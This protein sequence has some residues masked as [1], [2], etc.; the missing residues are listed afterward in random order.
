[1]EKKG[2]TL[3][4][5]GNIPAVP[6]IIF[7]VLAL[8]LAFVY[9]DN[10]IS[11]GATGYFSF[12]FGKKPV[13]L[14]SPDLIVSQID[15]DPIA[16]Y[17]T[18]S[19]KNIG[20]AAS[21]ASKLSVGWNIPS[22]QTCPTQGGGSVITAQ[23]IAN[24]IDEKVVILTKPCSL[25]FDVPALAI[26]QEIPITYVGGYNFYGKTVTATADYLGSTSESN[27][28][29]NNMVKTLLSDLIVSD[30]YLN[31][32]DKNT[33]VYIDNIGEISS[34]A[35]KLSFSWDISNI[36]L[37]PAQGGSTGGSFTA[38]AVGDPV[39]GKCTWT[40]DVSTLGI[41]NDGSRKTSI[42][43]GT[44][45]EGKMVTASVDYTNNISESNESNNNMTRLLTVGGCTD[46]DN[47]SRYLNGNNPFVKGTCTDGIG[48]HTDGCSKT[49]PSTKYMNTEWYCSDNKCVSSKEECP[50]GVLGGEPG[51]C[52]SDGA[53]GKS[54]KE[55]E[56][57]CYDNYG[58]HPS[59][60]ASLTNVASWT[61][62]PIGQPVDN[63]CHGAFQQAPCAAGQVCN[64]GSCVKGCAGWA[65]CPVNEKCE[66]SACIPVG[67]IGEGS[68]TPGV[69]FPSQKL[70]H[71]DHECCAGLTEMGWHNEASGCESG[72]LLGSG[73]ICTGKCGN[74][75][76]DEGEEKCTCPAD[77]GGQGYYMIYPSVQLI[78]PGAASFTQ[79]SFITFIWKP[80]N[81]ST[82]L[83]S[84]NLTIIHKSGMLTP[85]IY[86]KLCMGSDEDCS[87]IPSILLDAESFPTGDYD[88]NVVCGSGVTSE[89]RTFSV[90][91]PLENC[92][93]STD[94]KTCTN[95]TGTYGPKCASATTSKSYSCNGNICEESMIDWICPGTNP[96]CENG[97][98]ITGVPDIKLIVSGYNNV[99]QGSTR[100]FIWRPLY[101]SATP[102]CQLRIYKPGSSEPV[103]YP[104]SLGYTCVNNVDCNSGAISITAADFPIG[105]YNWSVRCDSK[106]LTEKN[107]IS[108]IG[109]FN[110]VPKTAKC[111]K[112]GGVDLTVKGTCTDEEGFQEN[113]TCITE[114]GNYIME[115]S[116][117]DD[118]CASSYEGI[119]CGE[120]KKCYKG[121]CVGIDI[122]SPSNNSEMNSPFT[123][124][125]IASGFA[126]NPTC[127]L[128]LDGIGSMQPCTNG[129]E[130]SKTTTSEE[131]EDDTDHE[132]KVT[133]N[134]GSTS[135]TSSALR[136][137]QPGE[138][139]DDD[140][141]HH[142]GGTTHC[143][144]N[145]SCS[146]WS[147]CA[148]GLQTRT[149][150]DLKKCG[151]TSNRPVLVQ[152]CTADCSPSWGCGDWNECAAGEK[153]SQYCEDANRC[154][155]NYS[156]MNSRDCCVEDWQFS[157][158]SE[159]VDGQKFKMYD[160]VSGCGT[161]YSQPIAEPESCGTSKMLMFVLI[162]AGIIIIALAV[163]L[164]I[165]KKKKKGFFAD[166]TGKTDK[167][168]K[169]DEKVQKVKPKDIKDAKEEKSAVP[170]E[171]QDYV[172]KALNAGMTK[173]DVR[174][175]FIEAGWPKEM[176]DKV[177]KK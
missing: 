48:S 55:S 13:S 84:C 9:V 64:N 112:S 159:C 106:K 134:L 69:V 76:C 68:S 166:K 104:D 163:L 79:G 149:C 139:S 28:G 142:G 111:V 39:A 141:S 162:G 19:V 121:A 77:C 113:D 33:I 150:T 161:A 137:T 170:S 2:K 100:A 3:K 109:K 43:V 96:S 103:I 81:F 61:C 173:E 168:G 126:G 60:C 152:S 30:I 95:D 144:G 29:N 18:F 8:C 156:Y 153:Q 70:D 12:D 16:N 72:G 54:C 31:P 83:I 32:V 117:V 102:N 171:L 132:W 44:G 145:W 123:F 15:I 143:Y 22:D 110:V 89:T 177:L 88:W 85:K 66:N 119:S 169:P 57:T 115:F 10:N 94:S 154:F 90:A 4:V 167:G 38:M 157:Q 59:E 6:F 71:I 40:F 99:E 91:V 118:Q 63:E 45:F 120:G 80:M 49:W 78:S 127:T 93:V 151:T 105:E 74:G 136:F 101:F 47:S 5:F 25:S 172:K 34:A 164:I 122:I 75:V 98:C 128:S 148:N 23:I 147:T 27:K 116:C 135:V 14:A 133:C 108:R 62:T 175:R 174:A 7:I 107:I 131:V 92:N 124:R 73:N 51:N 42:I 52:I 114:G 56:G 155:A 21:S 125:W 67:C 36:Q 20:N 165:M 140:H 87:S 11:S 158:Y 46:T 24:K 50:Y 53:C 176:V 26:G 35:N 37:C 97:R 130:C 82:V 1:M 86:S 129:V 17:P 65:D 138:G 160:E 58:S 146:D 41:E